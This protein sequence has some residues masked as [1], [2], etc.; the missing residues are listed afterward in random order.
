MQSAFQPTQMININMSV[1]LANRI[2]FKPDE[3]LRRQNEPELFAAFQQSKVVK[4]Q[5]AFT[6]YLQYMKSFATPQMITTMK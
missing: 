3:V 5:P 6:N 4:R 1:R 2:V